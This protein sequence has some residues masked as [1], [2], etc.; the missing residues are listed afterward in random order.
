MLRHTWRGHD[1]IVAGQDLHADAVAPQFVE[2]LRDVV[3]DG[4][5][6]ADEAGQHQLGFVVS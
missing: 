2:H 1:G 4:I 5:R 6:E 3:E